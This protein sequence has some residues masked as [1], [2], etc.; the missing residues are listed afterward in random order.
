VTAGL[1]KPVTG[2]ADAVTADLNKPVTG[3][4]SPSSP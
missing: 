4:A 2:P 1:N 3:P